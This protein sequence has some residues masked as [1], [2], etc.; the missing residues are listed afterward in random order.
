MIV[1]NRFFFTTFFSFVFLVGF[2]QSKEYQLEFRTSE[3]LQQFL[4]YSPNSVPLVS[5]H[6][7]GPA[8]GFPENSTAT[9]AHSIQ[10]NPTI[11]ETDIALSKDSVLVMMH[12]TTLDRTTTG[13]GAIENYTYVELQEFF[14][15]DN[16]G[17]QTPYKIETLD[18]V[19]QWGRGKVIYNLD[20][21][22]GV[23]MQMIVDAVRKNKAEAYSVIITYNANQAAEVSRLAPELMISVSAKGKEDVERMEQMGV[24][25]DKMIAFVGVSEARPEV[26]EYLHSRNIACILGTMGNIDRSAAANGDE[27]F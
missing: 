9:F 6:R 24:R 3:E 13:T 27:F 5:A 20:I 12:D 17:N 25:A 11:I 2:S 10:L 15:E 1:P 8:K 21:K 19:L 7:G 18:A 23:P 4:R 14:L 26:Y 16:L 22:K